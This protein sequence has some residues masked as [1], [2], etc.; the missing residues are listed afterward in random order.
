MR[1]K[2]ANGNPADNTIVVLS[3]EVDGADLSIVLR[4]DD[5]LKLRDPAPPVGEEEDTDALLAAL[6]VAQDECIVALAQGEKVVSVITGDG[7]NYLDYMQPYDDHEGR[8]DYAFEVATDIS[9]ARS[10]VASIEAVRGDDE[11]FRHSR[12]VA[13][14]G[15]ERKSKEL[16]LKG[17]R[18]VTTWIADVSLVT[19]SPAYP[20]ERNLFIDAFE[21]DLFTQ[22]ATAFFALDRFA[23]GGMATLR[24]IASTVVGDSGEE[25][26]ERLALET[27][28]HVGQLKRSSP[29]FTTPPKQG[30][31]N[32][33][34][35]W[36]DA[37]ANFI[38]KTGKAGAERAAEVRKAGSWR[39]WCDPSEAQPFGF[40]EVAMR[41]IW[42]DVV[43]PRIE[44]ERGFV[45][46]TALALASTLSMVQRPGIQYRREHHPR[47]GQLDML[48]NQ[49]DRGGER[50]ATLSNDYTLTSAGVS[51]AT[52]DTLQRGVAL[53]STVEA[54]KLKHYLA[55][56]A[57]AQHLSSDRDPLI[58]TGGFEGLA[59]ELGMTPKADN[60]ARL[61]DIVDI[62]QRIRSDWKGIEIR[63]LLTYVYAKAKG[64]KHSELRITIGEPF[65]PTFVHWLEKRLGS[66]S[67][68]A[69]EARMMVP[70]LSPP[71]FGRPNE[72]AKQEHVSLDL[73]IYLRQHADQIAKHGAVQIPRMEWERMADRAEYARRY[74]GR[75]VETFQEEWTK[76]GFLRRDG[77]LF[78][79]GPENEAATRFLIDA[80]TLTIKGRLGGQH[81]SKAR[82][83]AATGGR[84][85][86]GK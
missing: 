76:S 66:A 35:A 71:Y 79:L 27:L 15:H 36:R 41:A 57:L 22:A 49:L 23:E 39:L 4:H 2:P 70:D 19:F 38:G 69:V 30:E 83:A 48:F 64:Q 84:R 82:M 78:S 28:G 75:T 63:G 3:G 72:W 67:P 26:A 45:P 46:G 9:S 17:G 59:R 32:A 29:V 24:G 80:G 12:S 47:E 77:N 14:P 34:D 55:R 42:L 5:A 62:F 11:F 52:I 16:T 58:I 43:K 7:E 81:T 33:P 1:K 21:R 86:R 50:V 54:Y 51:M 37:F 74:I 60:I 73:S 65:K 68:T 56:K 40:V 31:E 18:R 61:R 53:L 25:E 44:R 20:N 13:F 8:G 6:R 10:L 85:K